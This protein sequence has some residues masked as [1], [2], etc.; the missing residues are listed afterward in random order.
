MVEDPLGHVPALLASIFVGE[1]KVDAF[2]YSC[3]DY[4]LGRIRETT[5]TSCLMDAGRVSGLDD[6]SHFV[7]AEE[8]LPE[9]ASLP[10]CYCLHQ[11]CDQDSSG[12]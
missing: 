9:F 3:V 10:R 5:H 1:A 7:R 2:I 12:C 4:I 11:R 6:E 8:E